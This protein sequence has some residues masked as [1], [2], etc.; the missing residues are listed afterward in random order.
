MHE[1]TTRAIVNCRCSAGFKVFTL[2][3][4]RGNLIGNIFEIGN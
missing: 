2:I 4:V 1:R 3:I